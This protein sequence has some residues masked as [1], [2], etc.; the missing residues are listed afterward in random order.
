MPGEGVAPEDEV[1]GGGKVGDD[2]GGGVGEAVLRR[3][4]V[5]PLLAV[6][7]DE[8]ANLGAVVDDGHQRGIAGVGVVKACTK[9]LEAGIDGELVELTNGRSGTGSQKAG[10]VGGLDHF[11]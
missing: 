5:G 8:L 4:D 6:L 10:N 11:C 2:I 3:L 9:V 7:G 1:L